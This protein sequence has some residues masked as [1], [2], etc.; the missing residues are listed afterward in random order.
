MSYSTSTQFKF[1]TQSFDI[2]SRRTFDLFK[3]ITLPISIRSN[4]KCLL[5]IPVILMTPNDSYIWNTL[6]IYTRSKESSTV[7][8]K[9]NTTCKRISNCIV[10]WIYRWC[11]YFIKPKINPI[12]TNNPNIRCLL[13]ASL[14]IIIKAI[15]SLSIKPF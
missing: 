3:I 12:N 2:T 11:I 8:P 4:L 1:C 14:S 5:R 9:L 15:P 10:N 7:F 6:S 13:N